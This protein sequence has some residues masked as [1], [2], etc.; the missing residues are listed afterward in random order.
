MFIVLFAS[1]IF[2]AAVTFPA[3]GQPYE[4]HASSNDSGMGYDTL[5]YWT[6]FFGLG[7]ATG[8]L[9]IRRLVL[10]DIERFRL[11]KYLIAVLAITTGI[12]HLLLLEEHLEESV[13]FGIFFVVSGAALIGYSIVAMFT[14]RRVVYYVGIGGTVILIGLYLFTRLVFV[15]FSPDGGVESISG[16]DI[17]TKVIEAALLGTLVYALSAQR[18]KLE[19]T[20]SI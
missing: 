13:L 5:G 20:S 16:L 8:I 12:I 19:T 3:H 1:V 15:P 4:D 7:T 18:K 11:S 2:T 10:Q 14:S 17:L 9:L 6:G